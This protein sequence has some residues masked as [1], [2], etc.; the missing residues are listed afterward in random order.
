[1]IQRRQTSRR[2][3]FRCESS[4]R[5]CE[6]KEQDLI[7][8]EDRIRNKGGICWTRKLKQELLGERAQTRMSMKSRHRSA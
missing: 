3:N 8:Q 4:K 6:N 5:E 7:K 2:Q 1:M